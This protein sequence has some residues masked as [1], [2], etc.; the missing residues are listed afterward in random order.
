MN[1][2]PSAH[3]CAAELAAIRADYPTLSW[4][5][6]ERVDEGWDHVVVICHGCRGDGALGHRDLV[7]RFPHDEQALT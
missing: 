3:P 1:S 7:F 4:D 2:D 6:A 5:H